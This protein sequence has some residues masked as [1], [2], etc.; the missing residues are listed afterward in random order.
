MEH[1]ICGIQSLELLSLFVLFLLYVD[2]IF[3]LSEIGNHF[4]LAD[5]W[6]FTTDTSNKTLLLLVLDSLV[7]YLISS[8]SGYS[9]YLFGYG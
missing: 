1:I 9:G 5:C 8:L 3:V 6:N 7:N 2:F 4:F